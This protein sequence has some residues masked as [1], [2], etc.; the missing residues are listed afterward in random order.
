MGDANAGRNDPAPEFLG[1]RRLAGQ[2]AVESCSN[3]LTLRKSTS[4]TCWMERL[5]LL[6]KLH[7]M[8]RRSV[9]DLQSSWPAS[10]TT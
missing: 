3:S 4:T 10:W 8:S 6:I 5:S 7:F 1:R 2:T 9:I